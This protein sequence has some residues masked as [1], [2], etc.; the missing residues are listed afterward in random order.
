MRIAVEEAVA[1]TSLLKS[2]GVLIEYK[3]RILGDNKGVIN[4]SII[5]GST[6]KKKHTSIAYHKVRE[7]IA[8]GLCNAC[9]IK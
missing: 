7:C 4:N 5:P 1:I 9:Y 6:V 8:I 3:L 2:V